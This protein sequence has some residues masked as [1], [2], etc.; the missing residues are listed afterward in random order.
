MRLFKQK[1]LVFYFTLPFTKI[2]VIHIRSDF[3]ERKSHHTANAF[4][5][6]RN[7]IKLR[8]ALEF[9]ID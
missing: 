6:S 7:A 2:T 8:C 5:V 4:R 9:E 3:A 1:Y